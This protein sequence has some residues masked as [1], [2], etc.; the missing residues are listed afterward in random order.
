M[1]GEV[2]SQTRPR[3]LSH[4]GSDREASSLKWSRH[5]SVAGIEPDS[6]ATPNSNTDSNPRKRPSTEPVDYPRRRA[7]IACEVC[8]SRKSRCDGAKPKCRLC[9][10]LSAECVYREPGVKLDAGDKLILERLT[11]IESLLQAGNGASPSTKANSSPANTSSPIVHDETLMLTKGAVMNGLGTWNSSPASVSTM[12]KNHTT[13][14]LNLL[15]WP[16]IRDLVSKKWDPQVL[17]QLE[18]QRES[19]NL[20]ANRPIDFTHVPLYTQAFFN[21]VNVWYACVSPYKWHSLYRIAHARG[22]REGPESCLVLLVL[23]LGSASCGGTVSR[24]PEKTDPAGMA[25]FT[26]AWAMIPSLILRNDLLSA[27]CQLLACAYLFYMVR[28][29]EAWNLLVSTSM[30]LQLLVSG[31]LSAGDKRLSER[32]YWNALLFESDLLAELELPHSGIVQF[33]EMVGIPGYFETEGE[34]PVAE[35]DL[36]YFLAEIGLRRLL[37][38]VSNSIYTVSSP[39]TNTAAL[40][41]VVEELDAQLTEWYSGL[42]KA[43]KFELHT[44]KNPAATPVQV[45]LRL[46]YFACRTII[47][48]PYV[49]AVLI[50]ESAFKDPAVKDS[51]RKCLEACIRQLE[52][53]QAHHSG[54][55]PY[56]WQGALSIV[57]QTLL[58]MG[59]TLSPALSEL[60]PPQHQMSAIIKDVV[61]EIE[62][63][64][65]LAPSLRLSADII[66]EADVRRQASLPSPSRATIP[67]IKV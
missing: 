1:A 47:Y 5:S 59:A 40:E 24:L 25:F 62:R 12:P 39:I 49:L 57:S 14:A 46:R 52:N 4:S 38:R 51:C 36:W 30:K 6:K 17:V 35:D 67:P 44:G 55:L 33:E 2:K 7:T 31:P 29:L 64:A 42:P 20:T 22:F 48:R 61:R 43:V 3:N 58:V 19:L 15:H 65:H 34:Q 10:E 63:Y 27:Q 32:L 28:P 26:S 54:H 23:A 18:M 16:K 8:R 56:L 66:R 45:V 13:P 37:N 50:N 21:G 41:P 9:T 53:I 60:L 11:R